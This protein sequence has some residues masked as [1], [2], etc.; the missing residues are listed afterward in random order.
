MLEA[1]CYTTPNS[2][3]LPLQGNL[4]LSVYIW[5]RETNDMKNKKIIS[6]VLVAAM[7]VVSFTACSQTEETKSGHKKEAIEVQDTTKSE[8]TTESTTENTTSIDESGVNVG[9]IVILGSYE[10]DND[11]SNGKENIEWQVLA[12]DGNKI[13]VISRYALDCQPFNDEWGDTTWE[14]CTLRAWMNDTFINEAFSEEEQEQ[15]LDSNVSADKNPQYNINPGKATTDKVFLLSINEAN[16][17]FIDDEARTCAPTDYVKAKGAYINYYK[18][19][20]NEIS[21]A[22]WLRSP[23]NSQAYPAFVLIYGKVDVGGYDINCERFCV[24]PAMWITIDS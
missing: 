10:Q 4:I 17:F 22:W 14:K 21:C 13:L 16:Q 11:I 7:S 20:N 5:G 19:E 12:K 15:I 3:R 8:T 6:I 2:I 18:T 1:Y 24:R 23:G 9:D